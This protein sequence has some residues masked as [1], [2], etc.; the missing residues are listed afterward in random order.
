[1]IRFALVLALFLGCASAANATTCTLPNTLTNG[2]VVDATALMGNFTSLQAC[3]NNIDTNNIGTT[4]VYATQIKPLATLQAIF[5]GTVAYTFSNGLTVNVLTLGTPLTT[6]NGGTGNAIG[7]ATN[8]SGVVGVVNG[9]TGVTA[10]GTTGN[11]LTSSGGSWVS[12]PPPGA[13]MYANATGVSV[14]TYH[15]I[16]GTAVF[17][18]VASVVINFPAAAYFTGV[19]TFACFGS[20]SNTNISFYFNQSGGTGTTMN[21]S[22]G[23]IT[24]TEPWICWGT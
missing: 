6:A 8:V 2:T 12:A 23:S 15:A 1:M 11:V 4:G 20:G 16:Q 22:G 24:G 21:T 19:A 18:S 3:G 17:S 13:V 7:T 14:G 5:G 10:S 9:G